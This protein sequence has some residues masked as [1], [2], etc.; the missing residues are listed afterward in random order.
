MGG[1]FYYIKMPPLVRFFERRR[2]LVQI[3][4]VFQCHSKSVLFILTQNSHHSL[5]L[6]NG[7]CVDC[8]D[9]LLF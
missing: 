3:I 1:F 8:V 5:K 4:L 9:D 7:G 6:V 2:G